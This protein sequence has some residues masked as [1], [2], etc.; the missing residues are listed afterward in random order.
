M[1]AAHT[2][3]FYRPL[4]WKQI[5][6]RLGPRRQPFIVSEVTPEQFSHDEE[7]TRFFIELSEDEYARLMTDG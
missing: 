3:V 4:T 5:A 2:E 7:R 6:A 1:T